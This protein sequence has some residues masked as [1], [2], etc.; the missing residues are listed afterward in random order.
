MALQKLQLDENTVIWID[1]SNESAPIEEATVS[2]G[3]NS[4][5]LSPTQV[6]QQLTNM[7]DTIKTF[8]NYTLNA[9]KQ[10]ANAN[11][12]K[13]TLEFGVNVGGKAGIPYI[14]EGSIGSNIKVTV[15]CTFPTN[16]V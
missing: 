1:S 8:T 6:Q 12:N 3:R 5:A 4:R 9:F 10:V 2:Q 7:Q 16:Q 15:E 14:T 13:V 11:V